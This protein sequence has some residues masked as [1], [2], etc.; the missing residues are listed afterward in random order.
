MQ[1]RSIA[2]ARDW[3]SLRFAQFSRSG[4]PW[5][6]DS[7]VRQE[8]GRRGKAPSF[9]AG[10]GGSRRGDHLDEDPG[11]RRPACLRHLVPRIQ[12]GILAPAASRGRPLSPV[13]THIEIEGSRDGVERPGHTLGPFSFG[14]YCL[15]RPKSVNTAFSVAY[16]CGRVLRNSAPGTKLSDQKFCSMSLGT[17]A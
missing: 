1:D 10:S 14:A 3:R 15:A 11:L 13:L 17:E 9:S 4:R 8:L 5:A 12:T 7:A 2:P 16:S 6:E